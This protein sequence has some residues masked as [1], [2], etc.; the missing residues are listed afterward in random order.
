MK[1]VDLPKDLVLKI[2]SPVQLYDYHTAK[3]ILHQRI[4][5]SQHTFSFLIEGSKEV[6]T[7]SSKVSIKNTHFLMMKSGHC[8]MTER[9]SFSNKDYR[10]MLLFFSTS[11]IHELI[12]KHELSVRE[13][14][15]DNRSV[16]TFVYDDFIK[17]YVKSLIDINN[18]KP[19][20]KEKLAKVK[21]EELILYLIETKGIEFLSI[22]SESSRREQSNFN[23]VI[24]NNRLNKLDL[25][26]L[27]FLANM[28]VSTFKR[29][30]EKHYKTSPIKWFQSQRLENAATLL[31]T[32]SIRPS[33]IYEASGYESL[34]NF[35]QAFKAKYGVTPKQYQLG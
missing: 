31:S 34:T 25:R 2:D 7:E 8:L 22:F 4:I 18:L 9:L 10:S 30:F 19:D 15:N 33:D 32:T 27:A 29:A 14:N 5:L 13:T 26:E 20:I 6:I 3:E 11:Y 1:I 12:K 28:S 16:Q 35:I 24:D 21:L 17:Q 23:T